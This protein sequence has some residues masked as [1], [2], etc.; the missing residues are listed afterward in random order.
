MRVLVIGTGISGLAMDEDWQWALGVC[1]GG[2]IHGFEEFF[3]GMV[4]SGRAVHVPS[5]GRL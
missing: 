1:L 5:P 2:T 3:P 4:A